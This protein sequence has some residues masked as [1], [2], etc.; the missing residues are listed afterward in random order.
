[1]DGRTDFYEPD[2]QS[3][4]GAPSGDGEAREAPEI[5][6]GG[7]WAAVRSV[8][9]SSKAEGRLQ[10]AEQAIKDLHFATREETGRL[11][12][13][14]E[15][16]KIYKSGGTQALQKLLVRKLKTRHS[17]HE[18]KEIKS[19]I[20]ALTYRTEFGGEFVPVANG[21][22]FIGDSVTLKDADPERAPFHRSP[23]K[24]DPD[25]DCPQFAKHLHKVVPTQQERETL[26]EYVGYCLYHWGIPLHKALFMIGPTASGKSTTLTVIRKLLGKVSKLS[27][28][29]LVNGRFGPA[30]LEG[31]WANIRSDI[32][33]AVLKDI[34]LFK[35]I[36]GGDPIYV[37]RKF[38][39]GYSL[40]PTAKHLYSANQLP[41]AS[42]DD[43]AFYRR[44]LLVSFPDTIPHDER[45]NRAKLDAELESELD[46]ILR[47]AVQGLQRVIEQD[48]F[49]HDLSPQ[50]TR[51]RWD[52]HSSSI[53]RFKASALNVTGDS[54]NVEAKQEVFSAYTNYCEDQG[55]ST[56]TQRQLTRTLK[57][58]GRI[59]DADRTPP[60]HDKQ[61]SC[62]VGIQIKPEWHPEREEIPF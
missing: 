54:A 12:Y 50:E 14:D 56:E 35:E 22:L 40:R 1:M 60:H 2:R 23:A 28:Q 26:Q 62:Y 42:I 55:L 25:A 43:D 17:R 34:G 32:S 27:P 48:G 58:D 5:Q 57:R 15:G 31:A 6:D 45:V 47:W 19:K 4:G 24:W 7:T 39:Q 59:T 3:A 51:R 18:Q 20:K 41:E 46:G 13:Y 21:D 37:E 61:T 49:T 44:I 36:V 10:A 53:G 52:E 33:N 11:Y 8:Y 29:Q 38:E 9:D 16:E 30:E